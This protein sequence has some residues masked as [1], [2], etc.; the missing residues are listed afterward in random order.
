MK[1][2]VLECSGSIQSFA[3][4]LRIARHDFFAHAPL[5]IMQTS[6]HR[7]RREPRQRPEN[8]CPFNAAQRIIFVALFVHLLLLSLLVL[9]R[10]PLTILMSDIFT[11]STLSPHFL[12]RAHF[13]L[14]ARVPKPHFGHIEP[15]ANSSPNTSFIP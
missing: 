15:L 14:V 3:L 13:L 7:I 2:D 4:R 1:R 8:V 10:T 5:E 6:A 12:H 11:R 9:R